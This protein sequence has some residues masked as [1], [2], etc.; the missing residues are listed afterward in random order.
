MIEVE[1]I[2][3]AAQLYELQDRLSRCAWLARSLSEPETGP[4]GTAEDL[5][6]IAHSLA[7]W[8]MLA[9]EMVP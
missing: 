2:K 7:D 8:S 3:R 4:T 9:G 6:R 1:R 5:A